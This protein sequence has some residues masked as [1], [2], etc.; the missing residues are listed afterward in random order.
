MHK[1][2]ILATGGTIASDVSENG[3]T[4][5]LSVSDI[6]AGSLHSLSD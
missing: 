3:L 6:V 1:I 4:P 5:E 2:L